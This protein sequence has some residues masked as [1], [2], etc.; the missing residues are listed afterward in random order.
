MENLLT[1][2]N[3]EALLATIKAEAPQPKVEMKKR[4]VQ[5]YDFKKALRFSQDQIRTL[6]RIHENYA[7][8]L[9]SYLS[10]LLRSYVQISVT[11]VEQFSYEEFIRNV[12]KKS[13][14]GVFKAAPLQGSMLMEFSPDVTYIMLDRML[15]GQGDIAPEPSDLTEIELSVIERVFINALNSFQEAW[16]SVVKLNAELK[17]IE[18]NPQFLTTSPPNET[19]ILV[20]LHAKIGDVDGMLNI[21]LPHVVLEQ[22]LPK[23]SARH[24]LANQKKAI[25][26][27]EAVALEK[28][29]QNTQMEVRAVLGQS[30]IEVGDFLNLKVG[31]VIRLD[32]AYDDPVVVMVDEKQKFFAQP[33][34]SKG[35]TA[36]QVTAVYG[37][38]EEVND[39]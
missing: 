13:V 17:E 26:S 23:L 35:R 5:T 4:K 32:E 7:R 8:L 12:Q 33:G 22:V 29:V 31:D 9:T 16:S 2:E 6:T 19:V 34:V 10:T 27:H 21:C 39:N 30:M 36:V 11:S 18:V 20:S 25:E 15:G 37:E 28:K 24:W 3:I 14:L 1:D 38:G